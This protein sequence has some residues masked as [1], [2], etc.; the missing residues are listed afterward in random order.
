MQD[1][2]SIK[3]LNAYS[4]HFMYIRQPHKH[5]EDAIL[6]EGVHPIGHSLFP[7]TVR[8]GSPLDKTPEPRGALKNLVDTQSAA[9]TGMTADITTGG[10]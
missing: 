6:F 1:F 9:V 3:L 5:L 4:P 7:D 8:V 2:Y 10:P